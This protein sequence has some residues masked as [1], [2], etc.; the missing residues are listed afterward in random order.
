MGQAFDENLAPAGDSRVWMTSD[1]VNN[2]M[3]KQLD[4]VSVTVNGKNAYVYYISPTQVNVLT[5]ADAMQGPVQVL[6]TN[7]AAASASFTAQAQTVS[8]SFFVFNGGPYVAAT[9]ANGTYLGPASL[10]PGLTTPAKPGEVIALYANGFGS[11][12]TPV[13]SGSVSQSGSLP[14][15]PV[16][17]IGG[18]NA[19]VQY[20]S[21]VGPGEFLFNVAV[22]AS[23]ADG[24]QLITATYKGS[25]TQAGALITI[26]H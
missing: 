12:S 10:Y 23:I 7:N 22:P 24:D 8:P 17:K 2:Q 5:P 9:H 18:V 14:T 11:T 3:P 4:G 20:Y 19:I 26:Q 13:V 16:I 1:F 21:L 15:P 25:A 6:V